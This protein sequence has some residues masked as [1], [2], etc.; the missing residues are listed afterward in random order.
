MKML[1]LIFGLVAGSF[2]CSA[3]TGEKNFIDQNY[4][5]V[6]GTVEKE[7]VPDEIYLRIVISEK[8]KGKKTVEQQEKEM[9]RILENLGIDVR[10]DLSIADV[11][12]NFK[13]YFLKRTAIQTSKNYQLLLHGTQK[14][15]NL[16]V[17]LEGAGISNISVD[18]VDHSRLEELRRECK[19]EAVKMAKEKAQAYAE[20]LGQQ[21]GRALYI[22]EYNTGYTGR[23]VMYSNMKVRGLAGVMEEA[24]EAMPEIDFEKIPLKASILVRFELK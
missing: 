2:L 6:T 18:R 16:L 23:S 4:V 21:I 17:A 12:S 7:I 24:D 15:G 19:V 13:S 8:D 5:E 1:I 11:S 20:A 3:Q 22:N 9:V 10:K 14:L